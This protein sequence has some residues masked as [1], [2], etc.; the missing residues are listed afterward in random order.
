MLAEA[1]RSIILAGVMYGCKLCK[2]VHAEK[3]VCHWRT[4]VVYWQGC[5]VRGVIPLE[6]LLL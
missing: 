1:P 5:S 4:M 6:E 2:L 3:A